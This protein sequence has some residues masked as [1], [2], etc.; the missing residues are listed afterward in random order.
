VAFDLRLG[1]PAGYTRL[2]DPPAVIENVQNVAGI[3]PANA[4]TD[5]DHNGQVGNL[6]LSDQDEDDLVAFISTL[7]DGFTDPGG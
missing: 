6:G 7:S 5:L 4:G 3:L 2:I 1:P